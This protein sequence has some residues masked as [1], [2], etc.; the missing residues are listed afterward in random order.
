MLASE[1][2]VV[3]WNRMRPGAP[4]AQKKTKKTK[5]NKK[6]GGGGIPVEK[7]PA[8]IVIPFTPDAS[9]LLTPYL[10]WKSLALS[11]WERGDRQQLVSTKPL[12][13]RK[14]GRCRDFCDLV[15]FTPTQDIQESTWGWGAEQVVSP[16]GKVRSCWRKALW[17]KNWVILF[18]DV[19]ASSPSHVGDVTVYVWHK[20]TKLAHSFLFCLCI[21]FCL[22]GP[23]NC[24]LFHKFCR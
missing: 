18:S 2:F 20:A 3:I 13:H 23:F 8:G 11:V 17:K 21:C 5:Q 12:S 1:W 10:V 6:K 22:Y 19:P 24:I 16:N 15:T 4:V 9:C 7:R 14:K